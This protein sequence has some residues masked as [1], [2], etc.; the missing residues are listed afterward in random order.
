MRHLRRFAT[1]LALLV[2][3]GCGGDTHD[4]LA[5]EQMDT[6]KK[7]NSVLDGV[8]D[9]ATA[10]SAKPELKSLAQKMKEINERQAK[11]PA[12]TQEE[13]AA[14][15]SKYDKEMDSLMQKFVGNVMRVSMDPQIAA[16]FSDLDEVMKG[17]VR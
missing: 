9:Q 5:A 14:T 1:I 13:I 6:M 7:M 11:L 3:A 4:S 2:C 10:K 16:E 17:T 15:S 8:K 12:P